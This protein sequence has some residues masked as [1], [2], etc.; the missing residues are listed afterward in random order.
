MKY[1]RIAY[2]AL[3]LL[4]ILSGCAAKPAPGEATPTPDAATLNSPQPGQAVP[5]IPGFKEGEAVD[6]SDL[7]D[8][9]AAIQDRHEGAI[10][11]SVTMMLIDGTEVYAADVTTQD[12]VRGM[13]Y[14]LADGTFTHGPTVTV[15][16][17]SP[18]AGG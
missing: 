6:I 5:T 18:T 15:P 9:K 13:L 14:L 16:E 1:L 17:I 11:N 12:D 3:A 2:I 4:L 10:I 7:P 8:I